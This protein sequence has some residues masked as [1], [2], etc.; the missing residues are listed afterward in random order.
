MKIKAVVQK[1]STAVYLY[2]LDVEDE[3]TGEKKKWIMRRS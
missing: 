1:P 3:L 2:Y